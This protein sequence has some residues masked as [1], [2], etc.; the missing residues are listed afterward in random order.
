MHVLPKLSQITSN[1]N[2]VK[3]PPPKLHPHSTRN[4][5]VRR[6]AIICARYVDDRTS[7]FRHV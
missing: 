4:I 1:I 3:I 7:P 2:C 5:E 6:T